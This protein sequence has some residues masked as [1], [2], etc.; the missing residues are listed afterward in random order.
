M[1]A[2]LSL[3]SLSRLLGLAVVVLCSTMPAVADT[4]NVVFTIDSTQSS[5]KYSLT[6]GNYSPFTTTTAGSDTSAVDGHFLVKFDPLTHTPASIQFIQNDG[7]F[8][9][10]SPVSVKSVNASPS[11]QVTY[12]DLNWDFY[13]PVLTGSNGVFPATTTSFKVLSGTLTEKFTNSQNDFDETGYTGTVTS[14]LWTLSESTAGS[15]DWKLQVSGFFIPPIGPQGG[16]EKFTL[17]A[18]ATAHYGS[19]NVTTLAPTDTTASVLG[20]SS[21]IGG[22]SINLPGNSNGGTFTAQQIPNETGLSQQAIAAAEKNPIFALS[23]DSLSV[24]PQIWSVDYNGLQSGQAATLV[25]N[26]DPALLPV[27]TD[28]SKLGIWHFNKI[29]NAWEFGGTVNTTDHTITFVTTSFSPFQ[30]GVNVPE[31]AACVLAGL[32]LVAL[33]FAGLRKRTA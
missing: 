31:P 9:Q 1:S 11:M 2:R 32:G 21:A 23:T 15:G 10:T 22:V 20:G 17:S 16:T 30:L 6:G 4:Q 26:Y 18:V 3:Q 27:G 12:Q 5:L 8:Q 14:G 29:G 33:C 19:A 28:E 7:Y 25:F 24:H 13:S